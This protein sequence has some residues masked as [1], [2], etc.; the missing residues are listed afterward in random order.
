MGGYVIMLRDVLG[1]TKK[2]IIAFGMY[3]L[4]FLVFGRVLSK[5]IIN[6]LEDVDHAHD[7]Y[8]NMLME[9]FTDVFGRINYE[10]YSKPFGQSF[11]V[12]SMVIFRILLLSLIASMIINRL[13]KTHELLPSL[14]N[15]E[16]IKTKNV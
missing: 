4:I 5:I 7:N 14:R 13:K 8:L 3:I 15:F 1:E 10:R 2:F 6:P 16:A 12:V 11:V 9:F